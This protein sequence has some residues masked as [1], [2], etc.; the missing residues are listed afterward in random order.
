MNFVAQR[1][2]PINTSNDRAVKCVGVRQVVPPPREDVRI[3]RFCLARFPLRLCMY[4]G[5]CDE[6]RRRCIYIDVHL[7]LYVP[8]ATSN[9]WLEELRTTFNE[10]EP[11]P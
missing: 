11:D 1:A 7:Y 5:P 9:E 4:C 10:R 6:C 8:D 2:L 3:V